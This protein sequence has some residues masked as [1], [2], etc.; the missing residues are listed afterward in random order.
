M[1]DMSSPPPPH[2]MIQKLNRMIIMSKLLMR[3]MLK[4]EK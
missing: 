4:T 3:K 1:S 2:F